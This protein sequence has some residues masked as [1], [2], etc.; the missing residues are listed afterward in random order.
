MSNGQRVQ[1]HTANGVCRITLNRPDRAN[2]LTAAMLRDLVQAV[3]GAKLAQVLV[4]TGAGKVFSAG[5]DLDEVAGDLATD[6]NWELLSGLIADFDG[7]TI[8]QLN[9]TVAGGAMGM[10]LACDFRV[11]VTTAK[12]FYPALAKGV[13]PQPS[14]PTRCAAL[15]GPT[16]TAEVFLLGRKVSATDALAWGLV[17]EVVTSMDLEATV[18][19]YLETVSPADPARVARIKQMIN[20]R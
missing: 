4:L 5:A 1:V 2:A 18:Q 6:P 13:D 17:N 19:S 8:A 14:D 10:V 16:R 20:Q 3:Q 15:I 7:V 12:F 9:G 11:A